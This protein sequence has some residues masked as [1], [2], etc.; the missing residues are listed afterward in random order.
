MDIALLNYDGNLE[1]VRNDLA[2]RLTSKP[3]YVQLKIRLERDIRIL[4]NMIFSGYGIG[5][6]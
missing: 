1:E 3:M 2:E 5:R 4:D 6:D